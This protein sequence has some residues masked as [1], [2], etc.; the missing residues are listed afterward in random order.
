MRHVLSFISLLASTTGIF[1]FRKAAPSF[2]KSTVVSCMLMLDE[3]FSL[4]QI[5]YMIAFVHQ[6]CQIQ[7]GVRLR[8]VCL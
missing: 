1:Q 5:F 7:S 4:A 3:F 6:N 2:C 8:Y